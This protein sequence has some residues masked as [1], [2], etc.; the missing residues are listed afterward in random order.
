MLIPILVFIVLAI[1]FIFVFE[2][3]GSGI[4]MG[5]I[6]AISAFCVMGLIRSNSDDMTT[7]TYELVQI[8][9]SESYVIAVDEGVYT[10]RTS[11]IDG[12]VSPKSFD[13]SQVTFH[14]DPDPRMVEH[15][16][17]SGVDI[18][19]AYGWTGN[20]TYDVYVPDPDLG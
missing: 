17:S 10:V 7:E 4:F 9:D 11:P 19:S 14:Q 18:W 12:V 8:E 6:L 13:E 2:D 16:F 15:C 1:V 20:C 5:V 3:I